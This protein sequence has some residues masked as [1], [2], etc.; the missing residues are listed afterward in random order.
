MHHLFWSSVTLTGNET[1]ASAGIREGMFWSSVTLTGNGTMV[2]PSSA[3]AG[4]WWISDLPAP[5]YL[6][7]S[8]FSF[9]VMA[10]MALSC[11]GRS[12]SCSEQRFN[13]SFACSNVAAVLMLVSSVLGRLPC[14]WT[15]VHLSSSQKQN[16]AVWEGLGASASVV[17]MAGS[18][19]RS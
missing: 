15:R 2:V 17:L 9:P 10:L 19:C 16:K 11:S 8:T 14:L 1:P 7:A 18:P 12:S 13:T 3:T 4:T 6:M 5:M